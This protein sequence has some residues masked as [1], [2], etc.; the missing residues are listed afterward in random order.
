MKKSLL[1]IVLMCMV[2]LSMFGCID[3]LAKN[4]DSIRWETESGVAALADKYSTDAPRINHSG[5]NTVTVK[6]SASYIMRASLM[7][8]PVN[9]EVNGVLNPN[10]AVYAAQQ[11]MKNTA[12]TFSFYLPP[13]LENGIY[14]VCAS[15]SHTN[16]S[17]GYFRVSTA[18]SPHLVP[19]QILQ[20]D[21]YKKK[22]V[23]KFDES[24][25][26]D[27]DSWA[28]KKSSMNITLS[29]DENSV[30][31]S[32]DDVEIDSE[33]MTVSVKTENYTQIFP[34]EN[35]KYD[36]NIQNTVISITTPGYWGDS[37]FGGARTGTFGLVIRGFSAEGFAEGLNFDIKIDSEVT[38][39]GADVI[40]ALYDGSVFVDCRVADNISV[41][42]E[43][44][45]TV[46]IYIKNEKLSPSGNF[47]V[48]IMLWDKKNLSPITPII[49]FP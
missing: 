3:V 44:L 23:L 31:V 22:I 42:A 19:K 15:Y 46:P 26:T 32:N 25:N 49:Q 40:T 18:V 47:S 14:A 33:N 36:R 41:N 38:L 34:S 37:D 20:Y 5:L 35:K 7:I 11:P 2:A 43:R 21:D 28:D 30:E 39:T 16:Y 1:K 8:I 6:P 48:K 13:D 10:N 4:A 29:N 24:N 12:A 9:G 45:K 27:F 17:V